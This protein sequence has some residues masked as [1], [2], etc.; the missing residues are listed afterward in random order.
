MDLVGKAR[1]EVFHILYSVLMLVGWREGNGHL[2]ISNSVLNCLPISQSLSLSP[3]PCTFYLALLNNQNK[4]GFV[5][6]HCPGPSLALCWLEVVFPAH[7]TWFTLITWFAPWNSE[8]L[9]GF[10]SQDVPTPACFGVGM[11]PQLCED[12]NPGSSWSTHGG[13]QLVWTF[14]LGLLSANNHSCPCPL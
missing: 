3:S 10:T 11:L 1:E 8:C 5:H 6:R 2:K 4:E 14:S 12:P 9:L 13:E 7:W